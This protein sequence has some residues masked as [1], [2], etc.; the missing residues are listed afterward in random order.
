MTT[1]S[2]HDD[3]F[4]RNSAAMRALQSMVQQSTSSAMKKMQEAN[5]ATVAKIMENLRPTIAAVNADAVKSLSKIVVPALE[6]P[7]IEFD[8]K[9][10][11][12]IKLG[13]EIARNV[14][15]SIDYTAMAQTVAAKVDETAPTEIAD[16]KPAAFTEQVLDE[17]ATGLFE[18]R[19]DLAEKFY[20]DPRITT[21][22]PAQKKMFAWHWALSIMFVI[23]LLFSWAKVDENV[24]YI[25]DI[26]ST[27]APFAATAYVRAQ[28][29]L[30]ADSADEE[31]EPEDKEE[32]S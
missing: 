19:P 4:F 20:N 29:G 11:K 32:R 27:A 8:F 3:D 24:D 28:K 17:M 22:N 14:A 23:A 5:A 12:Q 25:M 16:I 30:G 7:K 1:V 10:L 6:M 18:R 31:A 2:F 21:L 9:D 15:S 13:N 26:A